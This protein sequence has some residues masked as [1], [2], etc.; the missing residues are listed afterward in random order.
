MSEFS[1]PEQRTEMP[2]QRRMGH[3]R[4]EGQLY[5]SQEVVMVISLITGFYML[6]IAWRWIWRDFQTFTVST[7]RS[8]ANA[9]DFSLN[10]V[11]NIFLSMLKL[12]G[13]DI[14]IIVVGVSIASV[15]TVMLQTN[16]NIKEK[17]IKFNW[18]LIKPL[19]GIKR[20]FS[21]GGL[22]NLVKAIGKLL[23]ILPI[24]YFSLKKFAPDMVKLIHTSIPS[25]LVYTASAI[26]Y[27]F[28][29]ILYVLV[30]IAIFDFFYG[31][32]RWLKQNKMTKEEVKDE[33]KAVEGDEST[34]R[35]IISKGLQ[36]IMQRIMQ[37]V[38][39]AD[40]VVTNPTH[41][42]VALKYERQSMTAPVVVA[43]G[44]GFLALRIREIA[45]Q[46]GV[47]VLERKSLARALYS[48][49][50]IGSEIPH[51][52]FRAV[53]EVL[54]YVYKIRNVHKQYQAK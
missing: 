51:A 52:L 14:L 45:R 40:V 6:G 25:I 2:T 44:K 15:L 8:I 9:R 50:E 37:S 21:I 49:V 46:N 42:A 17:W 7:F 23:L 26:H 31:R 35:K 33:H 36:R 32:Y 4:K 3:L 41:Y 12:F 24:A 19:Q 11:E 54:A 30:A 38:P 22:F 48:S 18:D 39:K 1:T 5:M 28:W 53:A 16:W 27:I 43:K 34:K 10:N 47:P 20:I 13:P 29:K